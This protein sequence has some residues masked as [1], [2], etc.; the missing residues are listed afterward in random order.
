MTAVRFHRFGGPQQLR[1]EEIPLPKPGRGQ[2]LIAVQAAS[3][4][5]V[6]AK[7]RTGK[8]SGF[9]PALPAI[10]GRDISGVVRA[11]GPTGGR[12]GKFKIGQPV[13]GM[14]DYDRGA[15]A[16]YTL[17][18]SREVVRR[19]TGVS[20][21]EAATLGVAA[22]TAWQGLFDHGRLR[23]GERVLIH[24]GAGGVGHFAVQFAKLRGA[25]VIATAGTR[26]LDWV[27]QLGADQV[28]DY[29]RERFEDEVGDIDLVFDL[30]A[31]ETQT[32]SW[33]VLK[34]QG[35]RI[36][37][38]LAEPD[39]AEK[40]RHRASGERIVVKADTR[41]LTRIAQLVADGKV[42]VHIGKALPLAKAKAAHQLI[43]SGHLRGK[44]VL[45]IG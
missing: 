1:V 42:K 31:G 4:N 27:R 41:E 6:D 30:I 8:F 21:R 39:A 38:T 32:R 20:D 44:I 29:Q 36:V 10:A 23:R 14:L 13:F 19:P 22:L 15:Y 17:A 33:Q 9:Q 3:V 16:R 43:E 25:T 11:L 7:I 37:S 26:D 12:R 35:G 34:E 24:G 40:R 5:P 18:T 2:L 45:T 28:I